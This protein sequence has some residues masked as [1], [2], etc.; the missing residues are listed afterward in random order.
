MARRIL[1]L[2]IGSY[3]LKAA[4]IETTL[5]GCRIVDLV[6]QRREQER[7]LIE[8]LQEFRTAHAL[9]ADTVL[10]CLPGDAVSLRFL[11][12]PFTRSRQL[13]QIVSFELSDHLPFA[14]DTVVVD[15]HLVR[16]TETG[17]TVLAVAA[18]K[19]T[20][21]DHLETLAAAGFNPAKIDVAAFAPLTLLHYAGMNLHGL[22]ALLDVGVDRT[23]ILLMQDGLLRGVR[24]LSIGLNRE[25]GFPAFI[26][27][28]R[29]TLLAFGG[30]QCATPERFFLCGGGSRLSRLCAELAEALTTSIIPF[31][32]LPLPLI[33]DA[34]QREQGVYANCLG[35][36][37]H[38]ALGLRTPT[39]NLRRNAFAHQERREMLRQ[40]LSRLGW[41]AAGV[42][43]AAGL[44]F[45]LEMRQLNTRYNA[46]R[47]EIR[48]TFIATLPEVQTIVSEKVQLREAVD[49]LHGRQRLLQ[50]ATQESPLELLR[51]LSAAI[52]EQISLDVD[53]WTFDG[54][55]VHLQGSTT[56]F[57]AAETIKTTASGLDVFHDVQLKDV[58][59]ATGGKKV[60][61]GLQLALAKTNQ[62]TGSGKTENER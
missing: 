56:S 42:A 47:Q 22:T 53:E 27:E 17:A 12:L 30:A 29:W 3:S 7:P 33:P 31:H 46:L 24:T 58:K 6:Q 54:D 8:Q 1:A 14:P 9:H 10:S 32:E 39:V 40:E 57:D 25:G 18:P 13:E 50:G 55:T 28:L 11:D 37:L 38:E 43:V 5:R 62:T 23:S 20:L 41:L 2:D 48:K 49:A 59:T 52:P 60:S 51:R 61:F 26:R 36:G 34:Q 21:S 4:V 19:I 44:T 45:V 15:F 35:L 16:R